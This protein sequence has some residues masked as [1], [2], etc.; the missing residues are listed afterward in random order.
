MPGAT[1]DRA[2][3]DR[4][5]LKKEDIQQDIEKVPQQEV[6]DDN[7]PLKDLQ[8][9]FDARVVLT[10][11]LLILLWFLVCALTYGLHLGWSALDCIYFLCV[12]LTTVGYGDLSPTDDASKMY[13]SVFIILGMLVAGQ[14]IGVVLVEF[15]HTFRERSDR[16]TLCTSVA[17][18]AGFLCVGTTV[19]CLTEGLSFVDGFYLTV[20]TVTSVGYG[21]ISPKSE[22]GRIFSIFF[23][24]PAAIATAH[25]MSAAAAVP[26]KRHTKSLETMVIRQYGQKL[27]HDELTDLIQNP[28]G[29]HDLQGTT[30][31]R[32]E[33]V[34]K[35]LVKLNK[36]KVQ[37]I[38]EILAEF[39]LLDA[40]KSG[41]I[42]VDDVC[43]LVLQPS[44]Q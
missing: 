17:I 23:I 11:V 28:V 34:L 37:T 14:A 38:D 2:A 27:T 20:V 44:S 15:G 30:C 16:Q 36:V 39:D 22:A 1:L 32:N 18:I 5:L 21:D 7:S 10:S 4:A 33:F 24:L 3:S 41:S 26:M 35:L 9:F 43:D 25:A 13:T 6:E 8:E 29:K 19:F 31:D 42:S 40:D 12:T